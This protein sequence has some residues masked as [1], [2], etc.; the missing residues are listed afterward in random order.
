MNVVEILS[1]KR[2]SILDLLFYALSVCI[3]LLMFT[4]NQDREINKCH[5]RELLPLPPSHLLVVWCHHA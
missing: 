2:D 1:P 5:L 3:F 4:A